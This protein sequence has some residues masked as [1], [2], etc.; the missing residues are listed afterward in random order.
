[1]EKHRR[2]GY[3]R[4]S[5]VFG[6][7]ALFLDKYFL[8]LGLHRQ[9]QATWDLTEGDSALTQYEKDIYQAYADGVND[10]LNGVGLLKGSARRTG[11]LMPP[12]FI[13][14]GIT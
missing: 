7:D 1:M 10:F 12:E 13:L 8:T 5:E 6:R 3:G 2:L 4:L 11:Y 9:A 14:L